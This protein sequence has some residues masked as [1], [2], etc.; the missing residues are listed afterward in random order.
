MDQFKPLLGGTLLQLNNSVGGQTKTLPADHG[1]A[2]YSAIK[3]VV[4]TSELHLINSEQIPGGRG[5]ITPDSY[6]PIKPTMQNLTRIT[7]NPEVMGGKPFLRGLRVTVGTIIGLMAAGH[8]PENILE[9]YPYLELA[10]IYEALAYAAWRSEEIE[11]SLQ[12][13]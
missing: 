6:T 1:Y 4:Q 10:D 12:T 8:T 11:I 7:F 2:L 9:A 3:Q 5:V 13:A